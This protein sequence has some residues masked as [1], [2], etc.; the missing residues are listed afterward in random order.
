M[1]AHKTIY[2]YVRKDRKALILQRHTSW[3]DF[4]RCLPPRRQQRLCVTIQIRMNQTCF[5]THNTCI[6]KTPLVLMQHNDT[7]LHLIIHA[8]IPIQLA[9]S[10]VKNIA[11]KYSS[12]YFISTVL[13]LLFI[14]NKGF[15]P[16]FRCVVVVN[17]TSRERSLRHRH[18]N[19]GRK[20]TK[21]NHLI[22]TFWTDQGQ[23]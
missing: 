20:Q 4:G 10:G 12:T 19:R 17:A 15:D 7:L 3:F 22:F 1:L 18:K 5:V 21:S 2:V 6:N 9:F 8:H 23:N 11:N 14:P 16:I 13:T